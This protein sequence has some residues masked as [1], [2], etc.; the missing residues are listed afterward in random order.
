MD[1]VKFEQ[2]GWNDEGFFYSRYPAPEEG[3]KLSGNNLY[4]MI[5]FHK[6]GTHQSEDILVYRDE[7][8]PY[9]YHGLYFSEDRKFFNS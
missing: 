1:W 6:M 9:M 8:R 5:Y 7:E 3:Q 4:H 2:Y